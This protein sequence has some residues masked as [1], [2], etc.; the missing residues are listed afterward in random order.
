MLLKEKAALRVPDLVQYLL[1]ERRS[2]GAFPESLNRPVAEIDA[3]TVSAFSGFILSTTT[4]TLF[5]MSLYRE[6]PGSGLTVAVQ[7][8][9]LTDWS[10]R[11]SWAHSCQ[12]VR[13]HHTELPSNEA[14]GLRGS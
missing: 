4:H 8:W 6:P 3:G 10:I 2:W 11:L 13:P 5:P 9:L 1:L 14:G 12:L 7:G